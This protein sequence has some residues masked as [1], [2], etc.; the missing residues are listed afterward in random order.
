MIPR[1]RLKPF[2]FL[3]RLVSRDDIQLA[4]VSGRDRHLVEDAIS[5][6]NL[7]YPDY[8]IGDVGTSIYSIDNRQW[9]LWDDWQAEIGYCWR[10]LTHDQLHESLRD[11]ECLRLQEDEK[12]NRYKLS[13]YVPGDIN[14][15]RFIDDVSSCLQRLD[16]D[17]NIVFSIDETQ[18]QGLLDILPAAANKYHAIEYLMR[19]IQC[20]EENTL[21]AG[22]SGNDIDVLSSPLRSVLVANAT[23]EVRERAISLAMQRDQRHRLYLARGGYLGMNGNYAAGILEG[24]THYFPDLMSLFRAS[25]ACS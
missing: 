9:R 22:D 11:I 12:Q 18:H 21:F 4:Y 17:F 2:L 6:Y 3:N 7:P 23:A 16:I 19:K 8:V 20:N 25:N 13:Y 10:G 14:Q 15:N 24:V 1:S 5:A